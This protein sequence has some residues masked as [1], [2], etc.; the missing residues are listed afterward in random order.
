MTK[1][2][3]SAAPREP[4]TVL[5]AEDEALVR[6]A[7]ADE[8]REHGLQVIEAVDAEEAVSVLSSVPIDGVIVDLHL[9]KFRD[10]LA[11]AQHVRRHRPTIPVILASFETPSV[12]E[13]SLFDV[14][15]VKPYS[16]EAIAVW[17]KRHHASTSPLK[18]R[19]S[20]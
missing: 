1:A 3:P 4:L 9:R 5:V 16:P 7:L 8:L 15:F 12:H 20:A 2:N 13:Q 17:I 18:G 11:V 10:G 14:F 6:L 19:E